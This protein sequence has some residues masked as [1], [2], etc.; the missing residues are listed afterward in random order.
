V[1]NIT[2]KG[3]KIQPKIK[4]EMN[5]KEFAVHTWPLPVIK[6]LGYPLDSSTYNILWLA[7][8]NYTITSSHIGATGVKR[9]AQLNFMGKLFFRGRI[10]P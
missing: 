6:L 7:V 4:L 3:S 8:L 1:R 2:Q 5:A 10:C 9:I